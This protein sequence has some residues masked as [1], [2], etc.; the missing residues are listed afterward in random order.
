MKKKI[1]LELFRKYFK[2]SSPVDMYKNLNESINT[3]RNKFKQ[4]Q[5]KMH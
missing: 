4:N 3:E 2:Y 5:L 1:I